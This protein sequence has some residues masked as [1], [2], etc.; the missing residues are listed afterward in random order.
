MTRRRSTTAHGIRRGLAIAAVF[1]VIGCN[2]SASPSVPGPAETAQPASAP[3]P[4]AAS[5]PS[6]GSSPSV[7]PTPAPAAL[8]GQL[9]GVIE[10][11]AV[12]ARLQAVV[13][14]A[15]GRGA[16]DIMAAVITPRGTWSGAAGVGG[17]DLRPASA[18][19]AYYVGAISQIF[20]AATTLRLAEWA[21]STST[22]RW[23]TT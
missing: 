5:L 1:A 14:A 4:S 8:F 12:A 18:E 16:P 21:R 23:Q 15:V 3:A 9:P 22:H 17:A 20:T 11:A 19:D 2:A 13:D 6:L 10:D 7:N